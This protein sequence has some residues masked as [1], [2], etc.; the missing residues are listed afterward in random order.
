MPELQQTPTKRI[1]R[2]ILFFFRYLLIYNTIILPAQKT[3]TKLRLTH[4]TTD[5]A[6][7]TTGNRE[8]H[9]RSSQGQQTTLYYLLNHLENHCN[10]TYI[11]YRPTI[12]QMKNI[13]SGIN[14]QTQPTVL[15]ITTLHRPCNYYL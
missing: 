1:S 8:I 14:N 4:Q 3:N 13:I 6:N 2:K 7:S 9:Q 12:R 10:T 5:K 15:Q 11:I